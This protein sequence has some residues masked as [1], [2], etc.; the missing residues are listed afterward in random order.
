MIFGL[1][2]GFAY[3]QLGLMALGSLAIGITG[4]VVGIALGVIRLPMLTVFGVDPLLAAGTN[5][6]ISVMG[7]GFSTIAA[8][9]NRNVLWMVVLAMGGPA[10]AG[11]FIGGYFSDIVPLWILLATVSALMVWSSLWLVYW[12]V[13]VF[14]LR[15]RYPR[16]VRRSALSGRAYRGVDWKRSAR[17]GVA[18]LAIGVI[19]GAVG[20]VLGVLRMPALLAMRIEPHKAAATNLA[21]TVLVGVSGFGGHALRGNVDWLLVVIVGVPG[22]V[23]MVA[24]TRLADRFDA[25][26]LRFIVGLVILLV[27]PVVL[28]SGLQRL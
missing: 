24:G 3:W 8:V 26:G 5:L 23:G 2:S 21:I 28:W 10:I 16:A 11:A 12:S 15:R 27:A 18:G 25:T 22:V 20:L 19:G 13:R 9:I 4:G 1:D 7:S 6:L 17:E 14:N